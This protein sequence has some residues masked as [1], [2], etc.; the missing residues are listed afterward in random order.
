MKGFE[1]VQNY[2]KSLQFK[3]VVCFCL[4]SKTKEKKEKKVAVTSGAKH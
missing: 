4:V 2:S 3:R 1:W